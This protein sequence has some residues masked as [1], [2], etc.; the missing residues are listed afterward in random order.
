MQKFIDDYNSVIEL[1]T[2]FLQSYVQ[3]FPSLSTKFLFLKIIIKI[4][5]S[6][7]LFN[8]EE[9]EVTTNHLAEFRA[10]LKTCAS[11]W[12]LLLSIPR[13]VMLAHLQNLITSPGAGGG[14]KHKAPSI[15]PNEYMD[16][17]LADIKS[18]MKER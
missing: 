17:L 1:C 9:E 10:R 13:L 16:N 12:I 6:T 11:G 8:L 14:G 3:S 4:H 2:K 18:S 15:Q 7:L 5:I